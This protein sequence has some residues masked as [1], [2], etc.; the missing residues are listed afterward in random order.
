MLSSAEV[1]VCIDPILDGDLD[2]GIPRIYSASKRVLPSQGLLGTFPTLDALII[3][4]GLDDHAHLR[5]L[6]K[7]AFSDPLLPV[8]APPSARPVLE[9]AQFKDVTYLASQQRR[10]D[11]PYLGLDALPPIRLPDASENLDVALIQPRDAPAATRGA[12]LRVRA[13]SGALVGPP[14]QQ[15][16]NGYVLTGVS[17]GGVADGFS[18]Y[19][20]PHVEYDS[21]ELRD[22]APVDAV[23]T[24]ISGQGLPGFELVHGSD[25]SIDLIEKLR[26][27]YVLPMQNGAVDATG[28]SSPF[29]REFGL[30]RLAFQRAL[31]DASMSAEVIDVR[32]GEPVCIA[33]RGRAGVY[34]ND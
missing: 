21:D 25:A 28:L 23:I 18:V 8:Y 33:S 12:G 14:W 10:I 31:R 19:V 20:E 1:T 22:I 32:P 30:D 9:A 3:T 5:T 16:E 29:I 34:D 17:R 11:L 26:P 7:I 15:R 24:P 4:Q 27:Q 6:T 2:F 13:T